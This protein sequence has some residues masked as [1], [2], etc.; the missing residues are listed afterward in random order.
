[1]TEARARGSDPETSRTAAHDVESSGVA[2]D[3]RQLCL[4]EVRRHPGQTAAEIAQA[5]GLERHAP[6]RRLPELRAAG[7]VRNGDARTCAVVGRVSMTWW[8]VVA[9]K[10]TGTQG[11]L[12]G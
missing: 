7:L 12:F 9:K 3:Q 6:S 4:E 10:W 8:A 5:V 2:H 1:M 11:R